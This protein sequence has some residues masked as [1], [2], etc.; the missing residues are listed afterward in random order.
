M[1]WPACCLRFVPVLSA[2]L[3]RHHRLTAI[4]HNW[5]RPG[6]LNR[7]SRAART[8]PGHQ[9]HVAER[10]FLPWKILELAATR[11]PR[12][13]AGSMLAEPLTSAWTGIAAAMR[14]YRT[15]P[16]RLAP[17]D[18][19]PPSFDQPGPSDALLGDWPN[20]EH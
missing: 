1:R 13:V 18:V 8:D 7:T 14:S 19:R 4:G 17:G 11:L 10:R 12:R 15:N 9:C 3:V 6:A 20:L 16:S 2:L 5:Q